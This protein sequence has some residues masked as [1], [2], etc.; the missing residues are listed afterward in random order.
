MLD[1]ML[2]M[3]STDVPELYV[4]RPR[5]P[6]ARLARDIRRAADPCAVKSIVCG[7]RGCGKSTELARLAWELLP[8]YVAVAIDVAPLLEDGFDTTALLVTIAAATEAALRFWSDPSADRASAVA[9]S[10]AW[11]QAARAMDALGIAADRLP[12][13]VDLGSAVL[14]AAPQPAAG[15]AAGAA[16][17]LIGPRVRPTAKLASMAFAGLANAIRRLK[18]EASAANELATGVTRLLDQLGRVVG[19]RALLLVEGFDK[20]PAIEHVLRAFDDHK[21][22][23]QI[24]APTIFTGPVTL[25]HD[26]R[27]TSGA[28][29]TLRPE[30]FHNLPVRRRTDDGA[31]AWDDDALGVLVSMVRRRMGRFVMPPESLPDPVIRRAAEM[32]SGAPREMFKLLYDAS[33][34]ALDDDRVAVT[35]EDIEEQIKARR[36]ELQASALRESHFRVLREVLETG[37]LPRAEVRDGTPLADTLLYEG[38]IVA[39]PNGD[40]WFRP[41]EILVDWLR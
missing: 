19:G 11:A 3:P 33:G 34:L 7:A 15:A 39:Y 5:S 4:P 26:E 23:R 13:V 14:A 12:E 31:V 41:H 35:H 17:L 37:R 16:G 30:L 25:Q 9:A 27:F 28:M 1:P 18:P 6:S 2:A 29:Q 10:P 20:A 24:A 22:L 8:E 40:T 21:L 32:S 38:F 36:H